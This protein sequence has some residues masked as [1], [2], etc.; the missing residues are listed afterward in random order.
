MV[1]PSFPAG[2][3]QEHAGGGERR[4]LVLQHLIDREVRVA[5][6]ALIG[7]TGVLPVDM[8][9]ATMLYCA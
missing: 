6:E 9:T 5:G 1:A 8:F 4:E 7:K 2:R 3:P